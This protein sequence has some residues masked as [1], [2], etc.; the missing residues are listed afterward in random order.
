MIPIHALHHDERSWPDPETF[1]PERFLPENARSHH[2]S[3]YLPFGAGR[4]VCA[5]KSFAVI[6]G[7]LVTAM[8][9]R[10]FT[11]DLKPG[12]PVEPEA[13]LTLRPRHGLQMIARRRT[14]AP[15]EVA[16]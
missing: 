4:R 7:T 3:A 11:F 5:G 1:D 16:A 14:T 13:T 15:M 8:L 9:S 10:H 12:F 2:R 6:E